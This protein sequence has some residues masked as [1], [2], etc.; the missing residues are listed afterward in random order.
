MEAQGKYT[1]I[2]DF[3]QAL[4][5]RSKELFTVDK[6]EFIEKEEISPDLQARIEIS[7]Y[8]LEEKQ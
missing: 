1:E 7:A 3:C 6:I 8:L 5:K 4:R 2:G